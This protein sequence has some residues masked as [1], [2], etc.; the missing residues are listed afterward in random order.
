MTQ[1]VDIL[2]VNL[3]K[4]QESGAGKFAFDIYNYPSII[5]S[6]FIL[7]NEIELIQ[8]KESRLS[9]SQRIKVITLFNQTKEIKNG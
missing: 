9:A 1:P 5:T 4:I 6:I 8:K 7:N 2:Q 3:I